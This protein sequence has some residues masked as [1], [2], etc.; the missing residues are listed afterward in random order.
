MIEPAEVLA[1]AVE[2]AAR[3]GL[4]VVR[5]VVDGDDAHRPR[6][7]L[8]QRHHVLAG[9]LVGAQH[10]LLHPVRPEDEVA[11]DGHVERVLQ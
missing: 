8:A 1:A 4:T 3:V 6:H 2:A 10:G 7:L 9:E 5:V 11:V